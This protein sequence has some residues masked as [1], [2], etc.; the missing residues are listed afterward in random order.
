MKIESYFE[1]MNEHYGGGPIAASTA[2][3]YLDDHFPAWRAEIRNPAEWK[4]AFEKEVCIYRNVKRECFADRLFEYIADVNAMLLVWNDRKCDEYY[5]ICA[6][7]KLIV[8]DKERYLPIYLDALKNGA[9]LDRIMLDGDSVAMYDF[10]GAVEAAI[11]MFRGSGGDD[12]KTL[13]FNILS[14]LSRGRWRSYPDD[15]KDAIIGRN[16]DAFARKCTEEQWKSSSIRHKTR[17]AHTIIL[18]EYKNVHDL[19]NIH[20]YLHDT[21]KKYICFFSSKN[22]RFM[23]WRIDSDD[24]L[25]D[26][27][28]ALVDLS[29]SVISE[30]GCPEMDFEFG[31]SYCPSEQILRY[32]SWAKASGDDYVAEMI[33]AAIA[34]LEWTFVENRSA[35]DRYRRINKIDGR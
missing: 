24:S 4:P 3:M 16:W 35:Y 29:L 31:Y 1:K 9:G 32:K 22:Y 8:Y 23:Q 6:M 30:N 33:D 20:Q 19:L 13:A 18:E 11:E 15:V 5:R 17:L 7:K 2:L 28:D 21:D 10:P 26:S 12:D 14:M 27:G 25:R 34:E